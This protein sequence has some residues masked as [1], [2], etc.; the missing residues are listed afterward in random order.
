MDRMDATTTPSRSS[1]PAPPP[2]PPRPEDRTDLGA[3]TTGPGWWAVGAVVIG[4]I[5]WLGVLLYAWVI[6]ILVLAWTGGEGL[7]GAGGEDAGRWM[8]LATVAA[9]TAA[10]IP[11]VAFIASRRRR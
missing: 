2:R 4:Q 9:L 5:L 3:P 1:L 7:L 10:P 8:A 11:T 6:G